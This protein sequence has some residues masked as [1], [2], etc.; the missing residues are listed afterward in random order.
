MHEK[1][2][3]DEQMK[4]FIVDGYVAV[5]ADF[6]EEFHQKIFRDAEALYADEGNPGNGLTEE[7]PEILQIW[8]HP[9]VDGALH[10][11]LGPG[12]V[13][14][15]HRHGHLNPPQS[16]GQSFHLDSYEADENMRHHRCR[17]VL[18]LYYPQD[19]RVENGPTQVIEGSQYHTW[20]PERSDEVELPFAG[21]AGSVMIIHYE[22]WHRAMPNLS[23]RNRFMM[24]FLF[25][26]VNEPDRPS[27]NATDGDAA[28]ND[29]QTP[30][31]DADLYRPMWNR[32]WNWHCGDTD[33]PPPAGDTGPDEWITALSDGSEAIRLNAVYRL[34]EIGESA[35][36]ALI[37]E[38]IRESDSK[39]DRN[40]EARYTNPSQLL[41]VYAL[42]AIGLPAV[43]ALTGLLD[44]D[45]WWVRA[46]ASD[47][48]GDIG[49]QAVSSVPSLTRMLKDH[50]EWVRRN[51]AESLG[52]IGH[53]LDETVT[54]LTEAV[55]DANRYVQLN[56]TMS[57]VRLK[58]KTNAVDPGLH[59]ALEDEKYYIRNLAE[60][61]LQTI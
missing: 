37:E 35:I 15:P 56:A 50:S 5:Q 39:R 3:T 1:A 33:R 16:D 53:P 61:A 25:F 31:Y 42:S 18:A 6:P 54:A 59:I 46:A 26:R 9:A 36:P 17:W 43:S 8:K 48:L 55:R 22:L 28:G 19:V 44:H 57:L 10:S 41:S 38:L 23:D 4:R 40:L 51:A 45:D 34:A 29:W 58:G 13:M 24:K 49:A 21:R 20:E 52:I 2:L 47:A 27:W 11:I 30:H 60:D 7:I 12:Y 14:H 32:I